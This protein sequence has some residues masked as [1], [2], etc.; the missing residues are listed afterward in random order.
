M[1]SNYFYA[2]GFLPLQEPLHN[3]RKGDVYVKHSIL[4]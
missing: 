4:I 1:G 2:V 3:Q